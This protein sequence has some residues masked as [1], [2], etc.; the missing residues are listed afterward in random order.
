[1]W[2]LPVEISYIKIWWKV[3][4]GKVKMDISITADWQVVKESDVNF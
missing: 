2:T 4:F 3:N 1:M